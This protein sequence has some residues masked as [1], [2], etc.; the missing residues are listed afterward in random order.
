M[1]QVKDM[2]FYF[3]EYLRY[4]LRAK[5]EY[6]VHSPLIF[7]LY[8]KVKKR[9]IKE[10]ITKYFGQSLVVQTEDYQTIKDKLRENN[11]IIIIINDIHK[12]S[13]LFSLWKRVLEKEEIVFASIDFFSCGIIVRNER[14]LRRQDYILKRK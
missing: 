2:F 13:S 12:R 8:T 4:S 1:M 3:K 9:N 5:D 6:S 10:E 7:N 14:L 11:P